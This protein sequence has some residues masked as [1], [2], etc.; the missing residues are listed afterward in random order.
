MDNS[1]IATTPTAKTEEDRSLRLA[2]LLAIITAAD[3]TA[4]ISESL[5]AQQSSLRVEEGLLLG[6]MIASVAKQFDS[7]DLQTVRGY[8][9]VTGFGTVGRWRKR[10]VE[11]TQ[12]VLV[13]VR[14]L[15]ARRRNEKSHVETMAGVG[16]DRNGRLLAIPRY[17]FQATDARRVAMGD[18]L[19]AP[20]L[21]DET[22]YNSNYLN[23]VRPYEQED[24]STFGIDTN[25]LIAAV[26]LTVARRI[27]SLESVVVGN[28]ARRQQMRD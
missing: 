25:D 14:L 10:N 11:I 19:L 20:K 28:R 17:T 6:G 15:V 8:Y 18:I 16:F 26:R 24:P 21:E 5:N 9:D 2:H 7:L 1:S 23:G 27:E 22:L 3:E 12:R 13:D 4:H